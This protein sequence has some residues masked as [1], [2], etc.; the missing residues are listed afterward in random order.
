MAKNKTPDETGSVARDSNREKEHLA[1]LVK[2]LATMTQADGKV[3]DVE[4]ST[5]EA[6][7]EGHRPDH[8][9]LIKQLYHATVK[10]QPAR[11]RGNAIN[12]LIAGLD[13]DQQLDVLRSL[14]AVAQSDGE[15]HASEKKLIFEL[16]Q[17]MADSKD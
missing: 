7:L 14:W 6:V 16:M 12:K 9:E 3:L 2:L 5:A 15:I 1:L 8:N 13:I 4:N 10:V 11:K 17:T